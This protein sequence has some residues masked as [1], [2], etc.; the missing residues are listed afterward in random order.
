[1]KLKNLL[2]T[3]TACALLLSGCGSKGQTAIHVGDFAITD[4]AVK[5]T[6][7]QVMGS[8]SASGAVDA[9]KQ[10]YLMKSIAEEMGITLDEEQEQSI[11]REI[12]SFKA[13]QGGKSEG[14]KLLKKYGVN[15]DLLST[16]AA[17]SMYSEKIF[18]QLDIKKDPSDEELKQYFKDDYLR[19]KHVLIS[20]VDSSTGEEF[21]ENAQAE[22][23]KKANEV[24]EKAKNGEDFDAL[25]EEYNEDPGM[26]SN[27]EGYFFTDNQMVSEFENATKSIQPGE[28]TLCKSSFGYHIIQ[29][30]PID[31]AD[32]D[33]FFED[34]KSS[35][36]TTYASAQEQ[37]ALDAKAEEL[38][39]TTEVN[40]DVI[41][42]IKFDDN[43]GN[44]NSGDDAS[45]S[46]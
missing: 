32:F 45:S 12:G 41:D 35:A 4:N 26:S 3:A 43:S 6:A 36:Q 44:D 46:K 42:A 15:D 21:D 20:T 37:K 24:L 22:A 40:Q 27:A 7:E 11:K 31:G 18:E 25:I 10:S 23:E 19:A 34:N 17:S 39:I 13:N 16:I 1:M 38:G 2:I 8:P 5:F 33:R 30:L 28:F 29:R 14:D 9:L